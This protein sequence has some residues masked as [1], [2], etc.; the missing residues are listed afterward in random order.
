MR[1][2]ATSFPAPILSFGLLVLVWTQIVTTT[3][4]A[5]AFNRTLQSKA[6]TGGN[7]PVALP[8]MYDRAEYEYQIAYGAARADLLRLESPTLYAASPA[9]DPG[10]ARQI[11]RA[12][13]R[14]SLSQAPANAYAWLVLA[15]AEMAAGQDRQAV[16]ALAASAMFAP[17]SWDIAE[18]RASLGAMLHRT[19]PDHAAALRPILDRDIALL[20]KHLPDALSDLADIFPDIAK[21]SAAS[22]SPIAPD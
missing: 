16:Q 19:A 10:A 4:S 14:A 6:V 5:P 15:E 21:P 1:H 8:A 18:R 7:R 11:A 20:S 13:A 9:S 22:L 2:R 12:S 17:N 3:G